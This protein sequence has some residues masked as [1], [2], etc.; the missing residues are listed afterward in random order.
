MKGLLK[1]SIVKKFI[2]LFIFILIVALPFMYTTQLVGL[3]T[4]LDSFENPEYY[5]YLEYDDEYVIIQK[6]THPDFD[7]EESETIIYFELDGDIAYNRIYAVTG[8]GSFKRYYIHDDD[9]YPNE[10]PVYNSQV[11]GKVIKSVDNNILNEMSMK[12]WEV[13]IQNLNIRALIAD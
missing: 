9:T 3:D 10:R 11:I 4:F 6:S 7:I 12:L 13:S 2:K 5:A 1:K 8:I